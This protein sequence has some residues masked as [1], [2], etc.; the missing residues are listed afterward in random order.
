MAYNIYFQICSMIFVGLTVFMFFSRKRVHFETNKY[1]GL[2]LVVMELALFVDAVSVVALQ[3][4]GGVLTPMVNFWSRLYMFGMACCCEVLLCYVLIA[5]HPPG[6]KRKRLFLFYLM[7]AA[8]LLVC[9]VS[10]PLEMASEKGRHYT[11]GNGIF[12]GL[13]FCAFYLFS[14]LHYALRYRKKLGS[15]IKGI[16]AFSVLAAGSVL[17]QMVFKSHMFMSIAG[18]LS[19]VYMYFTFEN[20]DSLMDMKTGLYYK[21]TY[22]Q[23]LERAFY[24]KLEFFVINVQIKNFRVIKET[25]DIRLCFELENALDTFM[26]KVSD[27][28]TF[29]LE[30]SYAIVVSSEEE[31]KKVIDGIHSRFEKPW[32]IGG[33]EVTLSVCGCHFSCPGIAKDINQVF[34]MMRYG[35]EEAAKEQ[36]SGILCVEQ[37]AVERMARL[38]RVEKAVYCAME[39]DT[40][41]V[42]YQPIYC[43]AK[44]RYTTAEALLRLYDEELGYIPPDEF[45]P[46]A[47]ENGSIVRIGAMVLEK[48]C[49]FIKEN[50]LP[51]MGIEF[52]EVNLSVVQCMQENLA[53]QLLHIMAEYDIDPSYI[54]LELT[55]TSAV[56]SEQ[57]LVKNMEHLIDSGSCFSLDDY[58]SGYSNINYIVS[59]PFGIIKLDKS[60]I[61]AYFESDKAKVVLESAIGMIKQLNLAII[62]EGVETREQ[63]H[64]MI[65][66]GVDYLQ[67]YYFSKPVNGEG[68]LEVLHHAGSGIEL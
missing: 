12:A 3:K 34:Q 58:G 60:I 54:N 13:L 2:M 19:M 65:E 5:T 9:L 11:L 59:L 31:K 28:N 14:M 10:F 15:R 6:Q 36:K 33:V 39:K 51:K 44:K 29:D 68:F 55:E 1:Y 22:K 48:V 56:K 7:T 64:R 25:F 30:S 26:A 49:R 18:S 50:N 24:D 4:S 66:K 40:F 37:N 20:P 21:H 45:I 16:I 38:A 17:Y 35:L 57:K 62:G 63:A 53:E 27:G 43:V 8:V 67:G 52:V 23:S 61:W 41:E 42:Y 46:V 32:D 47:E